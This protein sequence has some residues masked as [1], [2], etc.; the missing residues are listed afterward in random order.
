MLLFAFVLSG[1][2][3]QSPTLCFFLNGLRFYCPTR[4]GFVYF[5]EE[6]I[7]P[8]RVA[9]NSQV[10]VRVSSGS[11]YRGGIGFWRVLKI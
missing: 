4:L 2:L 7:S 1:V 6:A 9:V 11:G 5:V 10:R 8:P 3:V